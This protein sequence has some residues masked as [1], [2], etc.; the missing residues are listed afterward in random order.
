M[1]LRKEE[2]NLSFNEEYI[3][4]FIPENI[5]NALNFGFLKNS[6]I[7]FE[8]RKDSS[9]SDLSNIENSNN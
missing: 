7:D 9:I 1:R 8:L 2:E 3:G 4:L 6:G 5:K